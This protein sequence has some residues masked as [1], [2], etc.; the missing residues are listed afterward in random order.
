MDEKQE[1]L[2]IYKLHAQLAD[3]VS[4]RRA[5]ANHFYL[6]VLSGLSVLFFRTLTAEKR[7]TSWHPHGRLW[8]IWYAFSIG[9]VCRHSLLSSV[10]FR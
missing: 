3:N 7:S 9:M 4:N 10:E 5:T 2:E 1:L 8:V 6:L